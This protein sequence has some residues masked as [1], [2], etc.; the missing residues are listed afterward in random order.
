[1]IIVAQYRERAAACEKLA[2]TAISDEHRQR[3][4][5]TAKSW[6]ELA[7]QRERMLKDWGAA[8]NGLRSMLRWT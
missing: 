2:E 8:E 3:I 6:R 7:N 4:L 5:E 1:M